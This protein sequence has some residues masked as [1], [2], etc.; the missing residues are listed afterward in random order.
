MSGTPGSSRRQFVTSVGLAAGAVGLGRALGAP[1]PLW[2]S[3]GPEE[4]EI[5]NEEVAKI[6]R[7][8]FGG[9]PITRAHLSLDMPTIAEDG[10]IVPVIIESDFAQSASRHLTTIH[11]IVDHNPDPLLAT[12]HL[13]PALGRVAISTRIKMKRPTWVRAIGETNDG[14]LYGDYARVNVGLNGC[15]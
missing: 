11:L 7:D 13:T 3:A 8:L 5:P 2:A 9:R 1:T 10:R 6:Y 14:T 4:P 12:F 15:G